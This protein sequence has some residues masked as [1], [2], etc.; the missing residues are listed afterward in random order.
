MFTFQVLLENIGQELDPILEPVLGQQTFKQG[1]A[2]CLKLGDSV[3]EYCPDFKSVL[4]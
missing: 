1:G 4:V 2:M 3:V